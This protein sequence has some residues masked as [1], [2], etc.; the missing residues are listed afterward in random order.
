MNKKIVCSICG[1]EVDPNDQ[2]P[3]RQFGT[4][5]GAILWKYIEVVG[6]KSCVCNVDKILVTE[7][8]LRLWTFYGSLKE[9]LREEGKLNEKI[10]R[11]MSLLEPVNP[12]NSD[13]V[14]KD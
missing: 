9:I 14:H 13:R 2:R 12:L 4:I 3:G 1:E 10:E 7:N 5:N 6:H 8:R 11:A